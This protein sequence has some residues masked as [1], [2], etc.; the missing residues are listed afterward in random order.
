MG[1]WGWLP[2]QVYAFIDIY[3]HLYTHT[4]THAD[5]QAREPLGPGNILHTCK[6][7]VQIYIY[8][9]ILYTCTYVLHIYMYTDIHIEMHQRICNWDMVTYECEYLSIYIYVYIHIHI[10]IRMH[11]HKGGWARVIYYTYVENGWHEFMYTHVHIQ[12]HKHNGN[13]GW[14]INVNI[15]L[16]MYIQGGEDP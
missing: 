3:I 2:Y 6:Y 9:D 4:C 14:Y 8:T 5:A 11:K 16:H 7:V 15:H 1:S 10:H 12:M 13:W